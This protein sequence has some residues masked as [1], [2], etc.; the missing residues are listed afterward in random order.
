[1]TRLLHKGEKFVWTEKC[2]RNFEELKKRLV[3]TAVLTL[4]TTG[5][6]FTIY[7][8]VLIQGLGCVLMQE[9]RV[10]AYASR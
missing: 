1:M 10:I 6:E 9:E 2:E 7:C 8:D 4:C 3:S 5:R